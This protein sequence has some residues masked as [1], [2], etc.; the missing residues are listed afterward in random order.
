MRLSHRSVSAETSNTSGPLAVA[1]ATKARKPI[2]ASFNACEAQ[3][4]SL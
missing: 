3:V 1:S 4:N 2:T